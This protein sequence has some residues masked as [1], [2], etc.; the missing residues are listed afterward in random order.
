MEGTIAIPWQHRRPALR[1]FAAQLE[2]HFPGLVRPEVKHPEL[3][4]IS[5]VHKREPER[6]KLLAEAKREGYGPDC[7]AALRLNS[8]G[9]SLSLQEFRSLRRSAE[10]MAKVDAG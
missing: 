5:A 8:M 10:Y 6:R 7:L 3:D 4:L 1:K 9:R 2:L